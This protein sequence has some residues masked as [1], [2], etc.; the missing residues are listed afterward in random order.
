MEK[1]IEIDKTIMLA[2]NVF[3][4]NALFFIGLPI[5]M[6]LIMIPIF[7]LTGILSYFFK[8]FMAVGWLTMLVVQVV[9]ATGLIGILLKCADGQTAKYKELFAKKD[10]FFKALG[11]IIVFAA[12]V[13]I[14][15]ILHGFSFR[16]FR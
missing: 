13:G 6:G 3:K 16:P 14:G 10:V 11:G 7:I 1:K 9:L 2:W 8:P 5:V 12:L 4:E 15:S